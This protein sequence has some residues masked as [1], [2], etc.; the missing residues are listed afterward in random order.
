MSL[1]NP[2]DFH[3]IN[4]VQFTHFDRIRA[5]LSTAVNINTDSRTIKKGEIFWSLRGDNFDG[6][7]FVKDSAA[8]GAL[9][10]VVRLDFTDREVPAQFPLLRVPDTLS[11]LQELASLHRRR[12]TIPLIGVTGSNGKTTLKEM[13]AHILTR[14]F[15]VHKTEGNYNNH[16]GC[17]LTL[18]KLNQQHEVAVI[19][20]GTNHPGEINMLTQIGAPTRA[21]ITNIGGAHLENFVTVAAIAKEKL[22]LFDAIPE[23]GVLYKNL[24]D[25][26][27]AAYDRA[28]TFSIGYS[29]TKQADV[30]GRVVSFNERGCGR[31]TLNNSIEIQLQAGGLHNI[32][33]ALAA[34]AVGGQFG[35]SAREIKEA[36]ESYSPFSKR[37]QTMLWQGVTFINDA[38]NANPDSM[39]A[40]FQTLQSMRISGRLFLVLGDMFELG[41]GGIQMHRDVLETALNLNPQRIMVMGL[42]MAEARSLFNSESI[43]KIHYYDDYAL[44]ANDLQ[45]C[46]KSGDCVL[47]KGSRGM[48]MEKIFNYF[49]DLMSQPKP[50][51]AAH[52]S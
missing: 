46:L 11:A 22:T 4:G 43:G 8:R 19:E 38:Y 7:L 28:K 26:Y 34:A 14:R 49:N 47:I 36:L 29:L 33:N 18:L 5:S 16:I 12:F 35:L 44:L 51:G 1:I 3:K 32:K 27:I 23:D 24:D 40:A 13:I 2:D 45:S 15:R 41:P 6:Q 48:T 50:D 42:L 17:P 30:E 37:M 21:I 25:P 9:F 52:V 10:A 31:F 20:M 39:K